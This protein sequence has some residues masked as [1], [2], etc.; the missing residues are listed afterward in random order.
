MKIPLSSIVITDR[1]RTD[2]GD[3]QSLATSLQENGQ[4]QPVL[5]VPLLGNQYRLVAGGRRCAAATSLGWQTI[6]GIDHVTID[7]KLIEVAELTP[8]QLQILEYEENVRRKGISWKESCS[9]I[10]KLHLLK[11]LEHGFAV[12]GSKTEAW[13]ERKMADFTGYNRS[14][15]H[16]MLAVAKE[17]AVTPP[18]KVHECSNYTEAV[19]FLLRQVESEANLELERR[20]QRANPPIIPA[21]SADGAS[22]S[23]PALELSSTEG[24]EDPDRV[25]VWLH[26]VPKAFEDCVPGEDFMTKAGSCVI[27]LDVPPAA[28]ENIVHLLR[29]N[30]FALLWNGGSVGIPGLVRMPGAAI[31]NKIKFLSNDN[32]WPFQQNYIIGRVF[33]PTEP[34]GKWANHV[35]ATISAVPDFLEDSIN[36]PSL[37]PPVIDFS[38]TPFAAD[39]VAVTCLNGINPVFVAEL[40]RVPLWFEPDPVIYAK[41]NA[42]LRA[43]Y[44]ATIPGVEIRT[45]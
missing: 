6:E 26:G 31:W 4:I 2:L 13:T 10:A 21:G 36:E 43:F 27:G 17:L 39:G 38:I 1:Q 44:E 33:T 32:P 14:Q 8:L 19:A 5:V 45:Y 7:G 30:G 15:V 35:S 41:K 25:V 29:P 11:Q 12:P 40:G 20:R 18:T 3:I 34:T 22:P 42:G 16:Y 28:Y 24:K 9:A 37:P 23:Q